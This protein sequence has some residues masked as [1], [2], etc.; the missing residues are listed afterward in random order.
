MGLSKLIESRYPSLYEK[1]GILKSKSLFSVVLI[2][3]F[4]I[5]FIN[6]LIKDISTKLTITQDNK[7]T[8]AYIYKKKILKSHATTTMINARYEYVVYFEYKVDGDMYGNIAYLPKE[9][10]DKK[11]ENSS[12]EVVY[13]ISKPYISMPLSEYKK[14]SYFDKNILTYLFIILVLSFSNYL[15]IKKYLIKYIKAQNGR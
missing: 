8:T 2:T 3:I 11:R 15:L 6:L 7:T 13:S 4:L 5:Y 14:I 9:S 12:D 10:W 1:R